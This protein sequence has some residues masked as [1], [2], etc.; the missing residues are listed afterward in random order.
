LN[1]SWRNIKKALLAIEHEYQ[2]TINLAHSVGVEGFK[3]MA[4]EELR[5]LTVESEVE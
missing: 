4:I 5:E 2:R 1:G 3:G